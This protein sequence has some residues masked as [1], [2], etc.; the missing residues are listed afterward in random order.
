MEKN[1]IETYLGFC[2]RARKIV[3][4]I[5]EIEKQRKGV[6]LILCDG[7]LGQNSLKVA[8]NTKELL[9]CPLLIT[10]N[11]QLGELLH[12]PTVK[13]VAIK[14]NHLASAII[15]EAETEFQFISY[16]GGTK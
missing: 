9:N 14:D 2:I 5:D 12:R 3:F 10:K 1:K 13:S 16:S 6:Y 8:Q 15:K 11:G 7:A 4:G